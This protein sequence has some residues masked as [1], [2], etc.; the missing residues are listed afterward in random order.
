M[1]HLDCA[2]I[3]APNPNKNGHATK[4]TGQPGPQVNG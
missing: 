4:F 1:L 2:A 3:S